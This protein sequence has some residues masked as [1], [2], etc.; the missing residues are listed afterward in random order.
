MLKPKVLMMKSLALSAVLSLP[1]AAA[2]LCV[3]TDGQG[4]CTKTIGAAVT[5]ASANDTINIAPGTYH[6][7]VVIGKAVSLLGLDPAKTIIDATGLPNG[8]YV[9]GIDNSSL[10]GVTISGLTVENANYEGILVAN[11]S[12]ITIS[13][14][15]VT[16]NNKGLSVVAGAAPTCPGI[17]SFETNEDM[18]CGEGIHLLGA[19]HSAVLNNTVQNNSGG[20][21]VSDDTAAAHDNLIAGNVVSN[22]PF[23]CGITLA[24]HVPAAVSG[25]KTALGVYNNQ[26]ISNQSSQNGLKGQGAGAGAYASAP[27]TKSYGNVIANNTLTG[28]GIPGVAIHGHAPNQVLDG[29]VVIGNTISGNGA[30]S[31]DTT[32]PGTAGINVYSVSPV[33][34]TVIAQNTISQ[35]AIGVYLKV[36]G[37][38]HVQGN[39]FTAGSIGVFNGGAGTVNADGN[40]WGCSGSPTVGAFFGGCASVRGSV[41][42]TTWMPAA[43]GASK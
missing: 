12:S 35:E 22:N 25:S 24:S 31:G 10:A 40:W 30:D 6:E 43:P 13:G 32:T 1:L 27:G 17:P 26:V 34:G 7:S 3:S 20:I 39:S 19:Q 38:V 18:D 11:S 14:N 42:V 9:N 15:V 41:T 33:S 5:A 16:G 21:L 4:G 2:T 36:P 37:D 28:N 23:A 29:N 8:I